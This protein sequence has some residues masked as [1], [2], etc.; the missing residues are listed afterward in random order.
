VLQIYR[1]AF[2]NSDFGLASAWS[3]SLLVVL[4]SFMALYV[5]LTRKSDEERLT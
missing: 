1:T 2:E 4:G 3:V 5:W